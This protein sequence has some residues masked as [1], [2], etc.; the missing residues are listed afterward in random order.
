MTATII[1]ICVV[2]FMFL[3]LIVGEF[4]NDEFFYRLL[5]VFVILDIVG[6]TV[7]PI[8]NRT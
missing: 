3:I 1:F 4:D 7:T 8:L 2:A 5:G 6:T